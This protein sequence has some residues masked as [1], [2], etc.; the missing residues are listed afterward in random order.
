MKSFLS[1]PWETRDQNVL[2]WQITW[3]EVRKDTED[4]KKDAMFMPKIHGVSPHVYNGFIQG[5]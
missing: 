1:L 5:K 3:S 4:E 2:L